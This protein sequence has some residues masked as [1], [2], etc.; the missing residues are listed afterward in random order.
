MKKEI[1]KYSSLVLALSLSYATA[2]QAIS[3]T[4]SEKT[5]ENAVIFDIK[6][7]A[8]LPF[9]LFVSGGI[10]LMP[11]Y[12]NIV[13]ANPKTS[14]GTS[15]SHDIMVNP[16]L[17]LGYNFNLLNAQTVVGDFNPTLS[18]YVGYKHFFAY[19][20]SVSLSSSP[21]S[22][23]LSN[24][25]GLN[26]GLRFSSSIPLGFFVYADA[27]ATSML[28]GSWST[29]G[30]SSDSGPISS[31]GLLL[32]HV[33]VGATFNLFNLLKLSA[34][35]RLL[36]VP[37]IRYKGEGPQNPVVLDDSSKTLVHSLELG[38]S[39]LFFSI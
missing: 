16:E 19:T 38:L 20:P 14:A 17:N 22:S 7:S 36:Y 32:P 9:N 29:S 18:P 15:F 23:S 1:L 33:G 30:S 6:G 26:F 3:F 12:A 11:S 35:Y 10:E 21:F 39:F 27:G 28:N 13:G 4:Y 2:A 34:G 25:G 24:A 37:D 31:N 5:K 8:N